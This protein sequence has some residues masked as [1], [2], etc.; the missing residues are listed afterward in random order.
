MY[1]EPKT[2][3]ITIFQ[4]TEAKNI[5]RTD[6]Y[7][8]LAAREDIRL[9]FF[10]GSKEKAEYYKKEFFGL[11]IIYEIVKPNVLSGLNKFFSNLSFSLLRTDTTGLRRKM[12]LEI[13]SNYTRYVYGF[14]F[15]KILARSWIRKIARVL[16]YKLAKSSVFSEYFNKYNPSAVFLAHLFDDLEVN[17][18]KEAKR[19]G[20]KTIGFINSWDKLTARNI[21]RVLPDELLV[22]NNIVKKESM[23]Y[24]DMPENKIEVVGIPQ[25]DWHINYKPLSRKDFFGRKNLD[26]NKKL[27]VYAPMGKAYSDSDWEI[28]DLLQNSIED[29]KIK[30]SQLLVRF[31]PNDFV[32]KEEIEKR[33]WLIY[34]MPGIRFSKDRGV[35][36]DMSF[37]DIKGLTD[38]LANTDLFICYASS[39]SIDAAVFDKPIINIDFEI[40]SKK[41]MI[42]SPT[43]FYK[44]SHYQ[45]AVKT[46]GICYPKSEVDFIDCVNSYLNDPGINRL[47]RKRLVSEQC[48]RLDGKSG[49]RV[50][51]FILSYINNKI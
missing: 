47:G 49:E 39:M 16:D 27:I 34:D 28:I 5:L 11:N 20:V 14:I 51:N 46:G 15:N 35:D 3:F 17:L 12:D 38:T 18:L 32:D 29:G 13:D 44:M 40:G 26:L 33:R 48:W 31:Q 41:P 30:N 7:K 2:I 10:V 24:A 8:N 19:R 23:S 45:K 42:K 43:H 22:F 36:W 25:Y 6:I 9:V 1:R 37:E 50:A 21:I 4:G